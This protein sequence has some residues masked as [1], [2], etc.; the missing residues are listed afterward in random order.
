L[1]YSPVLTGGQICCDKSTVTLRLGSRV[2]GKK[3]LRTNGLFTESI[4]QSGW[5]TLSVTDKRSFPSGG[6]P[7]LSPEVAVS[8][9]FHA[10]STPAGNGSQQN[11]PLTDARYLALGLNSANQAAAG[12]TT[13][14]NITIARPGNAGVASPVYRLKTVEFYVSVNGGSTWRRV[15]L[16]RVGSDWQAAIADPASGYVSIRSI[17]T[18]VHGDQTEQT[19]YRAYSV[20]G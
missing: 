4:R 18:D 13:K 9:R 7:T 16:R 14:L 2:V 10:S 20:T 1:F 12:G 17:V 15:S 11:A 3:T 8:Y 5:Y 6:A 19:V